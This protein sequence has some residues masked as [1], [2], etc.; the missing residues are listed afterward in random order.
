MCLFKKKVKT[1]DAVPKKLDLD[2]YEMRFTIKAICLFEELTGKSF[3]GFGNDDLYALAYAIFVTSNDFKCKLSTFKYLLEDKR[4]SMWVSEKL[5]DIMNYASQFTENVPAESETSGETI[6][7]GLTITAIANSLIV[8]YGVDPHWVMNEME[9]WQIGSA[10]ESVDAMVKSRYEEE[11]L[12][13]YLGILP[14]VDGKKLNK[15]EKLLPFPWEAEEK[16]KRQEEQLKQN[17]YAVKHLI[18]KKLDFIK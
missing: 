13:T 4:F 6:D 5:G 14:H 7:T 11:R 3:Y 17:E 16:K 10:F 8:Q 15:P 2:K 1:D 9:L 12:W 18:G